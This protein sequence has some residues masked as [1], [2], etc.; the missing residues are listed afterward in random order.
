MKM[1]AMTENDIVYKWQNDWNKFARDVFDVTLDAKQQEVLHAIQ[2]HDRVSVVS[3]AARGK[4]YVSAVAAMCFL[5]LTP[6]WNKQG[7]LTHNTKVALTAP[8]GGQIS[9]IMMP[10]IARLYRE[11]LKYGLPGRLLDQSVKI[12]K[13]WFLVGFK[14]DDTNITVWQ[15]FHAANVMY[16]VT[17]ASGINQLIWD[18]IEGNLQ[19]NSRLLIVFNPNSSKG[20]AAKSCY[21]ER[22][23][24]FKLNCLDAP[25]VVAKK[26][27]FVGQVGYKWVLDKVEN[28]ATPI[29]EK[30][31]KIEKNDFKFEG[32]WYRPSDWFRIKVLG[33]FPEVSEKALIPLAWIRAANERWDRFVAE[34]RIKTA[35]LRLGT[36]VAGMGTD[37]TVHCHRYG[38]FVEKFKAS[39]S[40][41]V[42]NHMETAGEIKH[43]LKS[44]GAMSFVDTVGEGAG[45]YSRLT[46][47]HQKVYSVKSNASAKDLTD[48]TKQYSFGNLRDYLFWAIRDWLNPANNS[49]ACLPRVEKLTEELVEIQWSYDS[50]GRPTID[51]KDKLK[52]RL[53]RSPDH[54]DSLSLTFYPAQQEESANLSIIA[55]MY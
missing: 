33:E 5:Y 39:N 16:I 13:E 8:N 6:K 38:N 28:E 37:D 51:R 9:T 42:A 21:S 20:Y 14:S 43:C 48:I 27:I 53:K 36:D 26:D 55:G 41:G 50:Q 34:Q 18:A 4:D 22:W 24:H 25:N 19:G 40:G 49:E 52:E 47:L 32:K 46:E 35:K 1:R 31:V 54:A 7:K 45:V 15:G 3:G 17:E 44:L 29:E 23:K 10:E 30:D 12:D 2:T 11:G